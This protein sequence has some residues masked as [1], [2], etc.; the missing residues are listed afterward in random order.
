MEKSKE[1]VMTIAENAKF[2]KRYYCKA[3]NTRVKGNSFIQK[4]CAFVKAL[5]KDGYKTFVNGNYIT[6][7]KNS[8]S[9]VF[10][11]TAHERTL[12]NYLLSKNLRQFV[13]YFAFYD[14]I[15]NCVYKV[16]Y[17]KVKAYCEQ[18]TTLATF[19]GNTNMYDLKVL[20]PDSWATQQKI[21]TY[22][23]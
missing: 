5:E 3:N 13:N 23:I 6:A 10:Y 2:I 21:N 8:E 14:N 16:S 7:T 12:H 20:V 9:N 1:K 18:I 19:Y 17:S 11:F 22:F 15:N 4:R